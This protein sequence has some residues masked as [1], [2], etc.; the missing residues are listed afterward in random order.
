M[1]SHP[2]FTPQRMFLNSL[3]VA[4]IIVLEIN[5]RVDAEHFSVL[6]DWIIDK[7]E[8]KWMG[9]VSRLGDF[10]IVD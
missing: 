5:S 6:K 1:E 3:C 10:T 9:W 7:V 4:F 2:T 8:G